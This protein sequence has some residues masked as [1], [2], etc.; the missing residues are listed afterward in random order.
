MT[1]QTDREEKKLRTPT[2]ASVIKVVA[3]N[4]RRRRWFQSKNAEKEGEKRAQTGEEKLFCHRLFSLR[5]SSVSGKIAEKYWHLSLSSMTD[6]KNIGFFTMPSQPQE[7]FVKNG[8]LLHSEGCQIV[9]CL[10]W[11][12]ILWIM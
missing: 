9:S 10:F 2:H 4:R 3:G 6:W 7:E 8:E 12:K 5:R 11:D 1:T